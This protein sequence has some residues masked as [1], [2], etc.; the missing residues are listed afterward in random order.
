MSELVEVDVRPTRAASRERALVL[1]AAGIEYAHQE[2]PE[3][4][5]L[6]VR[7]PDAE[8][9]V[10]ELS[11]YAE[12]S[13][14]WPAPPPRPRKIPTVGWPAAML[15]STIVGSF[16]ILQSVDA[17]GGDWARLGR[18]EG[19]MTRDGE[20]WRALTSL[21]LH[22]DLSHVAG[23]LLFGALFVGV[24]SQY[25]GTGLALFTTFSA[26]AIGN[27]LNGAF[28]GFT[29][30]SLG[31]STAVFAALGLFVS[32]GFRRK[33]QA[34]GRWHRR[35]MPLAVGLA[36]LGFLGTSGERT[37]VLAHILGFSVGL[38]AGAPMAGLSSRWIDSG[39]FQFAATM[40]TALLLSLAWGLAFTLE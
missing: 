1:E 39:R 33:R 32:A 16:W 28:R 14:S 7:A 13:G 29:S 9:A 8:R 5:R 17:F 35:W 25:L 26:G 12:E 19:A 23:N 27:L 22:A 18:T 15:W 30:T 20:W 6:L 36:F 3:G 31:A 38:L 24:A 4:W 37:D 21:T 2:D 34:G 10:L 11:S 40:A